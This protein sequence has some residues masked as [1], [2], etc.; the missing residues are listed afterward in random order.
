MHDV[1]NDSNGSIFVEWLVTKGLGGYAMGTPSGVPARAYHGLLI[2]AL[3]P[4]VDRTMLVAG[5]E[6]SGAAS[7]CGRADAG[8]VCHRLPAD[9]DHDG[10][11]DVRDNCPAS[12]NPGQADS[13]GDGVGNRC[14][15]EQQ[16]PCGIGAELVALLP[17]LAAR[18]RLQR[19]R[20]GRL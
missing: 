19:A 11:G 9:P 7:V 17:L 8:L 2:A 20:A 12:W 15:S 6:G 4:P 5:L 10:V 18:R 3:R 1:R 14:D 13:D 16:Q